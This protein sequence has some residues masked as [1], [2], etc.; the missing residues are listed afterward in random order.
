MVENTDSYSDTR[1]DRQTDRQDTDWLRAFITSDIL[2]TGEY[3]PRFFVRPFSSLGVN[4]EHYSKFYFLLSTNR[5][6]TS[7]PGQ[8]GL[9]VYM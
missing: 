8:N 2:Y 5:N 3:S 1:S 6:K 4:F 7:R 9:R